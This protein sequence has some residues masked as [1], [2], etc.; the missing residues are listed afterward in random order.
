M[1][2]SSE[3]SHHAD[4]LHYFVKQKKSLKLLRFQTWIL[5]E[6]KSLNNFF[7]SDSTSLEFLLILCSGNGTAHAKAVQFMDIPNVQLHGTHSLLHFQ[8][9]VPYCRVLRHIE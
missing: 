3:H 7:G 4:F 6:M 2:N 8:L 5:L 1:A 9:T